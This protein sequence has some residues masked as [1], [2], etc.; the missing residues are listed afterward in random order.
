[1]IT[2]EVTNVQ[3]GIIEV[4]SDTGDYFRCLLGGK[5]LR[6]ERTE[7]NVVTVGDKV[8]FGTLERE[9][10]SLQRFFQEK[11]VSCE[12][13]QEKEGVTWIR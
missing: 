8:V 6:K 12:E 2:G 1:M 7:K 9:Q 10:V 4:L 5:L 11:S 13:V 3:K